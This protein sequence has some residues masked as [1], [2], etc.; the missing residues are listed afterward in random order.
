ML[1]GDRVRL[2][3][4][5]QADYP[6]L[7]RWL[8]DPEI[9]YFWGRPGNTQSLAEIAREEDEKALRSSSKKFIIE[10]L[11]DE[12]AVIGQIDYY[13]LDWPYRSAWTSIMIGDPQYLGG[14]YGTDAMH[15]LLRYLFADL[16]LHRISLTVHADNV[17]AQR[18]YA[19]N[20][21]VEEG[22][23]RDWQF[24]DGR[25]HDGIMMSVLDRE[26]AGIDSAR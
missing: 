14:G 11:G 12:P 23:L 13:D 25:W 4:I 18:S 17:R 19:K 7:A 6:L 2:R 24:F 5:G 1:N 9:M 22:R 8:N 3:A 10:T 21:F 26:F 16:G 15:V 20:G